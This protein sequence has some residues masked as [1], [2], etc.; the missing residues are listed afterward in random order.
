MAVADEILPGA[1]LGSAP[2]AQRRRRT[3]FVRLALIL[4]AVSAVAYLGVSAVVY[5]RLSSATAGCPG[6]RDDPTS[7]AIQGVDT[8]PYWL[9]APTDVRFPARDEPR[10][11]IAAW[12][13]PVPAGLDASTVILV[14]GH[15]GCRANAPN[16]LAAGM[17]HDHGIAVLLIDLRNHGDSTVED[18]R[19]AGGNKEYRDVLGAWD[20]LRAKGVP[21]ARIGLLGFSLGAATTMIAMGQEPRIAAIWE[22]SS[23]ADVGEALRDELTRNGYPTFLEAG[24]IFIG[25]VFVGDDLEAHSPLE[26]TGLLYG[27][28]IFITHGVRDQRLT[29]RYA[30]ELAAGVAAHGQVADL[31]IVPDAGHTEALRLHPA[32][33]ERRLTAFFLAALGG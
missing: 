29:V 11:T 7:F 31:W 21:E 19:F 32:E 8:Q 23:Y 15:N 13:V 18:G 5:D 22:D 17:L 20:W 14:H 26:T 3:L 10:I 25:R 12:W 28:P 9:P 24:G 1:D 30:F 33:Y 6:G 27:R 2:K 4:V 16:E